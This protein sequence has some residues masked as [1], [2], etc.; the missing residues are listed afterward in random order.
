[1][2]L[3]KLTQAQQLARIEGVVTKLYIAMVDMNAR[4]TALDGGEAT[5]TKK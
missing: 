1:M 4:V 3:K 2:K 5:K